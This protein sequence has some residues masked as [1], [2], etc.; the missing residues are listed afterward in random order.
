MQCT[1]LRDIEKK[2]TEKFTSDLSV[3][4]EVSCQNEAF[5]H[6]GNCMEIAHTTNFKITANAKGFMKG[7][8]MPVT[9]N[10]CPFCGKPTKKE[11][12]NG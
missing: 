4:A 6:E 8:N 11:Q 5:I 7:K 10:Y 2:L 12:D 3:P 1:C 9:A